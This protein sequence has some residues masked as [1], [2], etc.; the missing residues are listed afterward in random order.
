LNAVHRNHS[1]RQ[2]SSSG[3]AYRAMNDASVLVPIRR[4]VTFADIDRAHQAG[5]GMIEDVTMVHP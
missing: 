1:G 2:V 4:R 5:F 3:D